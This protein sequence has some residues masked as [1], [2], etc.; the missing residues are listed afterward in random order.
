VPLTYGERWLHDVGDIFVAAEQSGHTVNKDPN[1]GDPIG[2]G[3]GSVCISRGQRITASIAYLANPPE[4]LTILPN[5]SVAR[6]LFR[7]KRA[8]GVQTVDGRKF[9][10]TREVIVSGGA[11]NVCNT[12]DSA[13]DLRK[14]SCCRQVLILPPS[15]R[16]RFSYSQVLDRERSWRSMAFRSCSTCQWWVKTCLTIAFLLLESS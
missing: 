16:H 3:M 12:N 4:N 14:S 1:S 15:R 11:L 13:A 10:A 5:A 8:I 6:V 9:L 7:D 2:M